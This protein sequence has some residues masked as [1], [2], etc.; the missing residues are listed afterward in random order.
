MFKILEHWLQTFEY[1][2]YSRSMGVVHS[3][4]NDQAYFVSQ[5]QHNKGNGSGS[6]N[7]Y[8]QIVLAIIMA[9]MVN[10]NPTPS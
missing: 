6:P 5:V 4:K 8:Q 3:N 2:I 10:G 7:G 1:S 9:L